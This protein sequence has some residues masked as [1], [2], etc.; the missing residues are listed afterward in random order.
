MHIYSSGRDL[1]K[2]TP[3]ILHGVASPEYAYSYEP[4]A[5]LEMVRVLIRG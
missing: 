2:V 3:V 5:T 1:C 4:K